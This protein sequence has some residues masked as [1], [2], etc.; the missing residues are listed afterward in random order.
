MPFRCATQEF[1]SPRSKLRPCPEE[2]S[3]RS[4]GVRA[5]RPARGPYCPLA[6]HILLSFPFTLTPS[7]LNLPAAILKHFPASTQQF[8]NPRPGPWEYGQTTDP[9]PQASSKNMCLCLCVGRGSRGTE[10]GSLGITHKPLLH[11]HSQIRRSFR[12]RLM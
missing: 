12:H 2:T 7:P 10:K 11:P 4:E 5:W 8:W 3:I 6:L 9:R 1:Q